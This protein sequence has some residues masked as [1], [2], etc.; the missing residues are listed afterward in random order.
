M[1]Y[2]N[3]NLF[4][5]FFPF[6]LSYCMFFTFS[7]VALRSPSP[8]ESPVRQTR[9]HP[10]PPPKPRQQKPRHESPETSVEEEEYARLDW[11]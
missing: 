4:F 6:L 7:L 3:M 5:F 9:K 1:I 2:F 8:Y 11:I 10:S